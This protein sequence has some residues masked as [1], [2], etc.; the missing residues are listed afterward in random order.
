MWKG[1]EDGADQRSQRR[2]AGQ[3]VTP[4]R[5]IDAGQNDFGCTMVEVR[6]DLS[7]DLR[8]GQ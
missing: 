1:I 8:N 5:N 3:V 4:A 2:G 7:Q 6:L